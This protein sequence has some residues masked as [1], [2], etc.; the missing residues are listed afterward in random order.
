MDPRNI[1]ARHLVTAEVRIAGTARAFERRDFDL[2][3]GSK[4]ELDAKRREAKRVLGQIG[5]DV[6]GI[7]LCEY[8][9]V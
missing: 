6:R 4:Q 3:L 5:Y 9:L 7:N 1:V 2:M 8:R